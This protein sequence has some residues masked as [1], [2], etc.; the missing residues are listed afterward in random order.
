MASGGFHCRSE[1]EVDVKS[2]T[3]KHVGPGSYELAGEPLP[4][5]PTGRGPAPAPFMSSLERSWMDVSATHVTNP[6]PGAYDAHQAKD[7]ATAKHVAPLGNTLVFASGVDRLHVDKS[8]AWQPGPGTY[9]EGNVWLKNT[10][11]Y[12]AP[13]SKQ[14]LVFDRTTSAPS[15]PSKDQS[16]GYEEGQAGMLIQQKPT[17]PMYTGVGRDKVGPGSYDVINSGPKPGP[18][19]VQWCVSRTKRGLRVSSDTPGPGQYNPAK[20]R[21]TPSTTATA[22][23]R[24]CCINCD[25]W[26]Q[27]TKQG[28]GIVV[29]IGGVDVQFGGASGTSQFASK[30]PIHAQRQVQPLPPSPHFSL[31]NRTALKLQE[32]EQTPGPGAYNPVQMLGAA[33]LPREMQFF[34]STA[35]RGSQVDPMNSLSAPTYFKNPGPGAYNTPIKGVSVTQQS[36]SDPRPFNA[37]SNRFSE[38]KNGV[39][40]PGEYRP[41]QVVNLAK[42]IA[43]KAAISKGGVF[44][45]TASRWT[46]EEAAAAARIKPGPGNY[47]AKLDSSKPV[48]KGNDAVFASRAPRFRART[49]PTALDTSDIDPESG[50]GQVK[51]DPAAL[52]PGSYNLPDGWSRKSRS[53]HT[54]AFGSESGRAVPQ[55]PGANLNTPGPGRYNTTKDVDKAFKPLS[56]PSKETV[57]GSQVGRF[58]T[59]GTYTP[60]VGQY[61]LQ[62]DLTRKSYNITYH[63][64]SVA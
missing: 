49:A 53:Y 22:H 21:L 36:L 13:P 59:N 8:G 45:S 25:M 44:G 16:Y 50:Q 39:P 3:G 51:G 23:H 18:K 60:G 47:D 26:L 11:H 14:R 12:R 43:D 62:Q 6:G 5:S 35:R 1:R 19:V 17:E 10:H 54:A 38:N 20:A 64:V 42:S 7:C 61:N 30:V 58:R 57:F 63:G 9:S 27:D 32:W 29:S 28:T 15:I 56:N 40:G 41:D 52:G 55:G 37:T 33:P 48:H 4:A 46:A 34:G 24:P 31:R 2:T